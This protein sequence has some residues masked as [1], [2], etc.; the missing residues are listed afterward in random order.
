MVPYE[1]KPGETPRKVQLQRKRRLYAEQDLSLLIQKEGVEAESKSRFGLDLFDD[2]GHESRLPSEW[3]P[4]TPGVPPTPAKVARI[5]GS[6]SSWETCLVTDYD[7]QCN[8]YLVTLVDPMG[9]KGESEWVPRIKVCFSAEDPFVF[10]RRYA[11][12]H[13]G[14]ARYESE[15]KN[16]SLTHQC[17]TNSDPHCYRAESLL[18][19]SLYIDSMPME[20]IDPL[21]AE[22]VNR[23]LSLAMNSRKLKDRIMESSAMIGEI[24]M[25]YARTMNKIIFDRAIKRSKHESLSSKIPSALTM[26]KV[27]EDIFPVEN[28]QVIPKKGTVDAPEHNFPQQ[29]SEFSFKTLLT[30]PEVILALGRIKIECSKLL[31][32]SIFSTNHTK[33]LRL[34]EFEQSQIQVID[35]VGNYLKDTWCVALKSIIK[36]SF[37]DVGKG[38]FNLHE[39]NMETYEFSK[40]RRFFNLVR[41]TMEDTL[42]LL[43]DDSLQKYVSFVSKSCSG[44]ITVKSTNSIEV[45]VADEAGPPSLRRPPLL[46]VELLPSKE[47]PGEF[48]YS[49]PLD[50]IVA[51]LSLVFDH[52]IKKTQGLQQLEPAV[53]E[54]LFW[55]QIPTLNSVHPLEEHV[56]DLKSDLTDAVSQALKPAKAY[57]ELYKQYE[58]LLVLSPEAYVAALEAK[59]EDLTL[60]EMKA[61]VKRNSLELEALNEALPAQGISIGLLYVSTVKAR[62]VLVKKKEKLVSLLKALFARIPRKMM[63]GLDSK[64]KEIEKNLR[65]KPSNLEEIDDQRKYIE[66]LPI[67]LNE[68]QGDLEASKPW[69][70]HLETLYYLLPEDEFKDKASGEA[71]PNRL[72]NLGERQLLNLAAEEVKFKDE[73][74][75]E[76]EAFRDNINELQGLVSNF[77][78]MSDLNKMSLVVG[79]VRE[80]DERIKAADKDAAMYNG[81]E[82]LLGVTISDYSQVKKVIDQFDPYYQFWTTASSWKIN[83]QSWMHDSWEKLNGEQVE[84]EVTGA[85]KV[86]YKT[87]K[88]FAN[89]GLEQCAENCE[90]MRAEVEAFKK[91]VP[92]VQALRNPGM[93]ERHWEGLSEQLGMRLNPDKNF[94][95][96]K[97]EEMV[98]ALNRL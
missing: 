14:R 62:E 66:A 54:S 47:A 44:R 79:E 25:E 15:S 69:Y 88:V 91:F 30:K 3:V 43:V 95:L 24:N 12:A 89:R 56:Q 33:S 35:Q 63:L 28:P 32:Q 84:R 71:G 26:V 75:A 9:A 51:K 73:M 59:G 13:T 70:E 20:D 58:P 52:G 80:L 87:S 29:F 40:L 65:Q 64:F 45:E 86:L 27:S 67:K 98:S 18:R 34:D 23:I 76:Q 81:R 72:T 94:T 50:S 11:A 74:F 85:Y 83:H 46:T 48:V 38:W 78:Q 10:A 42:R 6:S 61:E 7:E 8:L 2:A 55:A 22:Q 96:V 49:I 16:R 90:V 39:T 5:N 41:Y 57:L 82:G 36:S 77:A 37:K 68:L 4:K 93:R 1:T 60:N 19:Y 21:N 53:M 92:L 17:Q 31:K 97:A